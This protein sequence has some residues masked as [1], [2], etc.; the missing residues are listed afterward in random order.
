MGKSQKWGSLIV[1]LGWGLVLALLPAEAVSI[2]GY[3]AAENDRFANDPAY[4]AIDYDL[5][6]IARSDR[7]RWATLVS[8]NVFLSAAHYRPGNGHTV[9]FFAGND[10]SGPS[11]NRTVSGGQRIGNTDLWVGLLNSPVPG[12]ITSYSFATEEFQD[13]SEALSSAYAAANAFIFGQSAN[14]RDD[15]YYTTDMATGRNRLD[16]WNPGQTVDGRTGD[17]WEAEYNTSDETNW[18]EYEAFLQGGDSGGPLFVSEEGALTLTGVNWFIRQTEDG[19]PVSSGFTYVGSY[20][21]EV[22]DYIDSNAV[23]E[24]SVA[25]LLGAGVLVMWCFRRR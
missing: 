25:V 15:T 1:M 24:P 8:E 21:S 5:S 22:Q 6:G 7:G 10:P 12:S 23:P 18:V 9:T 14:G 4:V 19:A 3:S 11:I 20:A 17:V 2:Q 16:V 13:S